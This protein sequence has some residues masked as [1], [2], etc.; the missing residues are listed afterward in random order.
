MDKHGILLLIWLF[1]DLGRKWLISF[2][3][4]RD[5]VFKIG[6]GAIFHRPKTYSKSK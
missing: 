1:G 6:F 2:Y 5:P 4:I 3:S